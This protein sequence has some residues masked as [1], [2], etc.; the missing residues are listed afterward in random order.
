MTFPLLISA[1]DMATIEF[2]YQKE[3]T[4]KGPLIINLNSPE[5]TG[6]SP[7]EILQDSKP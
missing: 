3:M 7:L 4:H 1:V 2:I 6:C 5:S